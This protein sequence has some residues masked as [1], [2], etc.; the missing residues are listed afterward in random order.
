MA[1]Q[2]NPIHSNRLKSGLQN[3]E[4][5]PKAN[6]VDVEE[7]AKEIWKLLKTNL[8]EENERMARK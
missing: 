3:V 6:E 7:L 4:N 8:R 2:E 5:V 1:D